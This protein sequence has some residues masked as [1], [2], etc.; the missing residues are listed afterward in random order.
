MTNRF[1]PRQKSF[2][3]LEMNDP[4]VF[5]V[6][7][8]T[9]F[10]VLLLPQIFDGSIGNL[11][12]PR[13]PTDYDAIAFQLVKGN[14][15]A[16]DYKDP[17]FLRPYQV[18]A[19][20][21]LHHWMFARTSD[22]SEP[23][24][25]YRPPAL[26]YLLAGTFVVFGREYWPIR[27]I[28]TAAMSAAAAVAALIGYRIMGTIAGVLT[29][30]LFLLNPWS[31]EYARMIFTEALACLFGTL[32]AWLLVKRWRHQVYWVIALGA[33]TT[34]ALLAR[35]VFVFW[36]P[37]IAFLIWRSVD[38]A[39]LRHVFGYL[40]VVVVL[41]APWGIRNC[42]LLQAFMP[43]G[44][45]GNINLPAGYSDL[46]FSMGGEWHKVH[47]MD[48]FAP[49]IPGSAHN[50]HYFGIDSERKEA[51]YGSKVAVNWIM[52]NP[53]KSVALVFMKIRKLWNPERVWVRI[54]YSVLILL[55]MLAVRT[56]EKS[57]SVA[58]LLIAN[59]LAV[60]ATWYF[61]QRGHMPAFG[62]YC[63]LAGIG[64]ATSIRVFLS[65]FKS[66]AAFPRA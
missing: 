24:T 34:L 35:H 9:A 52:Q 16:A 64:M 61:D 47:E 36:V 44:S 17:D 50:V 53:G 48:F 23:L 62:P 8:V 63:V 26:P 42:M 39:R 33:L 57:R 25:A 4:R 30:V 2:K 55:G 7:L 66:P 20:R 18:P 27:V 13:D 28:N 29:F 31:S 59:T 38:R 32:I 12:G 46:A 19:L 11:P 58:A 15:Y 51:R 1:L 49:V 56:N 60:G 22:G 21:Q 5:A 43:L 6:L 65:T 45:E 37:A 3:Y 40:G 41:F 14:G 10:L 54:F